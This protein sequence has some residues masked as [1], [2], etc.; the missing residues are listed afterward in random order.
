MEKQEE[1]NFTIKLENI[2]VLSCI[3][4]KNISISENI[5]KELEKLDLGDNEILKID[6]LENVNLKELKIIFI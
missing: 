1:K 4:C 5:G 3:N 6:I 2:K